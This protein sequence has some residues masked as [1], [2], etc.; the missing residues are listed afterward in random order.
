ME[1]FFIVQ[2]SHHIKVCDRDINH[3]IYTQE[4][5]SSSR[6]STE[7]SSSSTYKNFGIP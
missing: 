5:I 4:C 6:S 2:M 3:C 7:S 1:E